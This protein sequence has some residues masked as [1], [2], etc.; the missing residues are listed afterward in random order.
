MEERFTA[1]Q[2]KFFEKAQKF[3]SSKDI[4]T[5]VPRDGM[6]KTETEQA[7]NKYI[8]PCRPAVRPRPRNKQLYNG[9]C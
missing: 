6:N 1:I 7:G 3:K 4:K 9:R 5:T 2:L 8:V